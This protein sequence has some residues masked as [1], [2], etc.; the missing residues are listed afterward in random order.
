MKLS[1][2]KGIHLCDLLK[3]RTPEEL[4]ILIKQILK[5]EEE[6]Q[7]ERE[8]LMEGYNLKSLKNAGIIRKGYNNGKP[9]DEKDMRFIKKYARYLLFK[10][11]KD[12]Q[13]GFTDDDNE[14]LYNVQRFF[15]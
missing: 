10:K 15:R 8:R 13:I 6:S 7:K 14:R 5:A 2:E 4:E 11:I 12:S 3:T 9:L 1:E